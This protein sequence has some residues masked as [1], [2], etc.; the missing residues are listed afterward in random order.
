MRREIWA[1]MV[2]AVLVA[3]FAV[4]ATAANRRCLGKRATIVGT[5][6]G[7]RIRGTAADDVIVARGGND[8]INSKGGN[9]IVCAGAGKDK[10]RGGGGNDKL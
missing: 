1:A 10:V 6:G 8:N 9:D 3:S 4:P 5:N 2:A 7:D